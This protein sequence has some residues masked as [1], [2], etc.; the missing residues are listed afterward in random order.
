ML[1]EA[2][3]GG[4]EPAVAELALPDV[5]GLDLA[6]EEARVL[7]GPEAADVVA[8]PPLDGLGD[9]GLALVVP[10][11]DRPRARGEALAVLVAEADAAAD[12]C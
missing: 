8:P 12:A 7:L 1:G 11:P 4:H 10:G 6:G 5:R 9:L 2:G 3:E